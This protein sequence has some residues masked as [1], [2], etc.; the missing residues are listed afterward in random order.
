MVLE[1]MTM[2]TL[3]LAAMVALTVTTAAA[4]AQPSPPASYRTTLPPATSPAGRAGQAV[5]LP[6]GGQ[7]VTTGGTAHYQTLGTPGGGSAV[8]V[9]NGAGSASVIGQGHGAGTVATHP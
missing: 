8:M 1:N 9:P 3:C 6:G 5:P 2:R 7:G 4:L